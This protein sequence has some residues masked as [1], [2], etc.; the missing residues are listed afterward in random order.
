L[1]ILSAVIPNEGNNVFGIDANQISS[2]DGKSRA[3]RFD[4]LHCMQQLRQLGNPDHRITVGAV[5][6][7]EML[8]QY[9]DSYVGLQNGDT[10]R[11]VQAFWERRRLEGGWT[12]FQLPSDET[13]P[14]GGRHSVLKW[15]NESGGHELGRSAR[16]QGR[17][18][19]GKTGVIVRQN[20]PLP[21]GFYFGDVYDQ[22]SSVIVPKNS[23]D[24]PAIASFVMSHLYSEAIF[25]I[26]KKR[27]VTTSV[28][29]KV[30]FDI[31]YWRSIAD[32]QY[33]GGVPEP[34][35]DD[36]T[37]WLFHGH[38]AFAGS[39][40]ELHVALARLC[41]YRW[42]AETE[43]AMRLSDLAKE[44][45]A[46]AAGLPSPDP[47]GLLT[48]HANNT[49]LPLADRLRAVLSAAYGGLPMSPVQEQAL[50]R[51]ADARVDKRE[52][53]DVTLEGWLAD[54]AFR[55][56]CI[57]FRQR[58]FLWQVWDGMKGG[59]SAFLHY[60]RLDR[61]ALDKLTYTLLGDWIRTAKAEGN[62]ARLERAEQLQQKL[63][64]IVEGESPH[65][66]FVRW[67]PLVKQPLGWDPDLD[68]GVRLNIRP[69]MKAGILR[70]Q[71]KGIS[72]NKDRGTEVKSAPWYDL[73]QRYQGKRGDRINDHHTTLA[74]KRAARGMS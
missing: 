58:P 66:I 18:A 51:A 23:I 28:F 36:P 41:G 38:P 30:P 69:F 27:N 25:H 54:R 67:K 26:Y 47:D 4:P 61:A 24:L 21:S 72:W 12:P 50:V 7:G 74:E 35:S 14:F 44:R 22:S 46:L 5:S 32:Q 37:Q 64:K 60:H 6:S 52:A 1:I 31:S 59:F 20:Q 42:P 11:W 13:Q 33:P 68:D 10:P 9:A 71:P 29:V 55:Q 40:T 45:I 15:D 19:W 8:S 2:P 63:A 48:L 56:H 49:A 16:V 53:R 3:I 70:D 34:Y 73:G 39:G 43:A 57:L 17:E 62:T 65:D